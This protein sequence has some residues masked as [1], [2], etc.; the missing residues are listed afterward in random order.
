MNIKNAIKLFVLISLLFSQSA[1]I[2][3]GQKSAIS[4]L[5]LSAGL[6]TEDL[7]N[8]LEPTLRLGP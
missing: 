2:L 8:L 7:N 5:A 3:P 4:S 1:A 6:S